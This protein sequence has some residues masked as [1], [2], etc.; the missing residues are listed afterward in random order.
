MLVKS[1]GKTPVESK[2]FQD[3]YKQIL[4]PL[5]NEAIFTLLKGRRMLETIDK[6]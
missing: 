1:R 3:V 6:K 2:D 5:I 4:M